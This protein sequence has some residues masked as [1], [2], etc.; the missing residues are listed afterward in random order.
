MEEGEGEREERASIWAELQGQITIQDDFDGE[1]GG[2]GEEEE[3]EEEAPEQSK[4]TKAQRIE[5]WARERPGAASSLVWDQGAGFRIYS[6]KRM[7]HIAVCAT[8]VDSGDVQK[9]EVND[10]KDQST[11]A[12]KNHLA[13]H[14]KE[15]YEELLKQQIGDAGKFFLTIFWLFEVY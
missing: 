14:H 4:L 1:A 3:E 5:R 6:K 11:T 9:A 8:C 10:G 2:G 15:L 7:P 13:S 12:L